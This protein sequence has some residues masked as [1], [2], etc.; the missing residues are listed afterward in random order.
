VQPG[1]KGHA[2]VEFD[3]DVV[4]R[5]LDAL[6][7]RLEQDAAPDAQRFVEALPGVG[8]IL[9]AQIAEVWLRDRVDAREEPET[10]FDLLANLCAARARLEVGFDD[11]AELAGDRLVEVVVP[12][13]LD[14]GAAAARFAGF[15]VGVIVAAVETV[16]QSS[17][18]ASA[19]SASHSTEISRMVALDI[20]VD[21]AIRRLRD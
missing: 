10:L 20:C 13:G 6:P 5:D 3:Q 7:T 11:D 4:G 12:G 2:R 17:L 14:D 21:W 18:T 15:A 1:A 9:L 19:A 8:P 16:E